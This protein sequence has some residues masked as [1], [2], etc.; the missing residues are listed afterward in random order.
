MEQDVNEE[1][2]VEEYLKDVEE[3]SLILI[4]DHEGVRSEHAR[5]KQYSKATKLNHFSKWPYKVIMIS[6]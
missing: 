4:L 2:E 6:Q 5:Q 1:G 3:L